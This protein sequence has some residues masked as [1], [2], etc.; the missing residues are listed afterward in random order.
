MNNDVKIKLNFK[1]LNDF[2]KNLN[3]NIEV[4]VGI[5][6]GKDDTRNDKNSNA[7]IG[8]NHEFP[9]YSENPRL[10]QRSWLRMPLFDK[11]NVNKIKDSGIQK[12]ILENKPMLF[13]KKLGILCENIIQEGFETG[14]FGKWKPLSE[15]TI[16]KKK[17]DQILINTAQL[18]KSVHSKVISE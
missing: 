11:L 10:P 18:R 2:K 17:S 3:K 12:D 1:G 8:L 6:S 4:R 5:L 9:A 16:A 7:T 15:Y 14:G 13:F